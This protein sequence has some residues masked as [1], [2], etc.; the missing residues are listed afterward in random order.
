MGEDGRRRL[1]HIPGIG[2][3]P[4]TPV[5]YDKR[6]IGMSGRTAGSP[7]FGV[8][9]DKAPSAMD[10]AAATHGGGPP[11]PALEVSSKSPAM[12]EDGLRPTP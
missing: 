5:A 2:E 12:G 4:V 9:L 8:L 10:L 6:G 11:R 7:E 3:G 1:L